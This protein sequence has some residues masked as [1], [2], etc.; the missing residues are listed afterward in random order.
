MLKIQKITIPA[1]FAFVTLTVLW[2]VLFAKKVFIDVFLYYT[3]YPLFKIFGDSLRQG[4]GSVIWI[5]SYLSGFPTYLS[6]QGGFLSPVTILFFKL[7]DFLTAFHWLIFLNFFAAGFAM[8]V[9][10]R[11]LSLSKIAS[12]VSAFAYAFSHFAVS[13]SQMLLWSN[14][15]PLIPLFFLALLKIH[16][17]EK[18]YFYSIVGIGVLTLG[19]LSAVIEIVFFT[20]LAGFFFALF[21]AWQTKQL[22]AVW[23]FLAIF[24]ISVILASPWLLPT[25]EF[26]KSLPRMAGM[27][28][29]EFLSGSVQGGDILRVFYPYFGIPYLPV[30]FSNTCVFLYV[31]IIPL[32]FGFLAFFVI[33]R[34]KFLHFFAPLFLITFSLTLSFLP[35]FEWLHRLP[36]FNLF[37][38]P[39]KWLPLAIFSWA[40][41]AGFGFDCIEQI[42]QQ[43]KFKFFIRGLEIFVLAVII[44]SIAV[45]VVFALFQDQLIS[46]V[47]Y[48]FDSYL[49]PKG[50]LAE[51]WSHYQPRIKVILETSFYNISFKNYHFSVSIIFIVI[52]GLIFSLYQRG[53]LGLANFK[54][55]AVLTVV[56]NTIFIWQ[57]HYLLQSSD[58][59]RG[60]PA[61]AQFLQSQKI[62]QSPFRVSSFLPSFA[63]YEDAVGIKLNDRQSQINLNTAL[64]FPNTSAFFN[65]DS[66]LAEENFMTRRQE[67]IL[68]KAGFEHKDFSESGKLMTNP[69]L[70]LAEKISTFS[71]PQNHNLL[72]MLNVKYILSSFEL[73]PPLKKVFETNVTKY[74]VPVYIY[75]N[76]DALP[77][78]YFV[79]KPV[80]TFEQ[81][82]EKIF[83]QLLV[84]DNFK[85]QTLIECSNETCAADYAYN[86]GI[87]EIAILEIKNGYL[88]LKTKTDKPRWLVYSESNLPTWEA[89]LKPISNFQFF[90]RSGI[91]PS[92]T[93]FN[94]STEWQPLKIYTANYIYQAVF[95]PQGEYEVEFKYPGVWR[96]YIY[97]LGNLLWSD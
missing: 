78:V 79:D 80:Y 65:I 37:R 30:G 61:T 34:E 27:S 68:I 6:Q 86:G 16:K 9:L 93:I 36:I 84:I 11:N 64:L 46:L 88:K 95:V 29:A 42:S 60:A 59:V 48:Y 83:E 47:K 73:P 75:E 25:F 7:F 1:I 85:N 66:I 5:S 67:N 3:H 57:G 20:I 23:G 58:V 52:A 69:E 97:S 4:E 54:K 70:S 19:C 45:N 90:P 62:D 28:I 63:H 77:R 2:P 31:G 39:F 96:Q 10:A 72:S 44:L 94:E 43:K 56:L 33:R 8:Y 32:I 14:L 17:R 91:P 18:V 49:Y 87:K 92:G 76:P 74:D 89:R 71:S 41:L 81:N 15:F 55:Y 21:L 35:F 50:V 22:R 13:M 40:I 51:P 53:K 82:K 38:G 26:S 24:V 12:I